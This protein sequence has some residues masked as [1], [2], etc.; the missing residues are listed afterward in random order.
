MVVSPANVPHGFTNTGTGE[1]RLVAIHGA[2]EFD[3]E[4]LAGADP[5]WTSKP[6]A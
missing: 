3:T 1:L 2:G 6:E 5:V 4:W